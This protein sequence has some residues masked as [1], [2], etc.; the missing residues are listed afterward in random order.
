D[1]YYQKQLISKARFYEKKAQEYLSNLAKMIIS[2]P[3]PSGQGQSCLP[4]ATQDFVDTGH[5]WFTPKGASTGSL[6]GT[7]YTL[8]AYYNY[9]PLELK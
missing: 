7:I 4:Y 8:F 2:S 9:N 3:S 5:G 1:Y 6:S